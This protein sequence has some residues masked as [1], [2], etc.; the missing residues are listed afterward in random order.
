MTTAA[1]GHVATERLLPE[2]L[3]T[4]PESIDEMRSQRDFYRNLFESAVAAFPHPVGVVDSGGV[5]TNWNSEL[6]DLVRVS[7]DE[8]VGQDAYDVVG[9]DGEDEVLS[10]QVARTG[11]TVV[12]DQIRS[13]ATPAG[14]EWHVRGAAFPLAGPDGDVVGAFQVNTDV[15]ELV[16]KNQTLSELQDRVTDEVATATESL[17]SA[18]TE[19]AANADA[20]EATTDEQAADVEDLR[21]DVVAVHERSEQAAER[22]TAVDERGDDIKETVAAAGES[23]ESVVSAVDDATDAVETVHDNARDLDEQADAITQLTETIQTVAT[24]TNMLA[25]NAN[26]EAAH[27]DAGGDHGFD[28]VAD[29]VKQLATRTQEEAE[30]VTDEVAAVRETID[31]TVDGVERL[32]DRL[33]SADEDAENLEEKQ[34]DITDHVQEVTAE[35]GAVTDVVDEQASHVRALADDVDE[36]ARRT[37]DVS[38][39]VSDIADATSEQTDTVRELDETVQLVADEFESYEL[40]VE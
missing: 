20:I 19:T 40:G 18:L 36:F 32:H 3:A 26:I 11:E 8:A 6:A 5:I 2:E 25:L 13:G 33:E 4:E 23:V 35:M 7:A 34:V 29:E 16:A 21:E 28:V 39:R 22:A 17:R 30:K 31:D 37:A 14:D 27:A 10:E 38:D 1:G 12:E 9:T 15:T 24:Q